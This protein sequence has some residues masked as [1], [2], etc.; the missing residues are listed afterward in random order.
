M[1]EEY[2]R[3]ATLKELL[4]A[5]K[6]SESEFLL[7]SGGTEIHRQAGSSVR[8]ENSAVCLSLEGLGLDTIE[9][10]GNS[11]TIGA[12]VTLQQLI[13]HTDVPEFMKEAALFAASRTLRN[14]ATLGGNIAAFRDDSYLLPTL[15]AAKARIVTAE[16]DDRGAID[17][18]D[19]PLREYVDNIDA[20]RMSVV[21][22]IVLNKPERYVYAKRYS[23][24]RQGVPDIIVAFGALCSEGRLSDVRT[25][26]AGLGIGIQRLKSVD[27][28]FELEPQISNEKLEEAVRREVHTAGSPF[29]SAEYQQYLAAVTIADMASACRK[30]LEGG[31]LQ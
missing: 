15:I 30:H 7:L 3:F 18:E 16:L 17:T 14:M 8:A 31:Q 25:A 4:T 13:D 11:V 29:A 28:L 19:M 5:V 2:R 20:F 26:A 9:K 1:I 24:T 10:K 6:E 23:R 21:T 22:K 12:M 27:K